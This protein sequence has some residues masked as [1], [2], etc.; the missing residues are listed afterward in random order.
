[1]A[2]LTGALAVLLTLHVCTAEETP[3][4]V[5]IGPCP[6]IP[7]VDFTERISTYLRRIPNNLTLPHFYERNEAMGLQLGNPTLTGLGDLW[8]YKPYTSACFAQ[9]TTYVEVVAFARVPLVTTVNWR[10]SSGG[11]GHMGVK[12]SSSQLRL[13][14]KVAPTSDDPV[15]LELSRIYPVSLED[16]EMFTSGAPM[17]FSRMVHYSSVIMKHQIEQ[18]W[19]YLLRRDAQFLIRGQRARA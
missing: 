3:F 16:A 13:V 5:S 7:Q 17:W 2:A 9:T 15:K 1:M 6:G 18:F 10:D 11:S 4:S 19:S 14:F 12:V 8:T